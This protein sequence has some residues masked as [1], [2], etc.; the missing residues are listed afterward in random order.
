MNEQIV[1]NYLI[2]GRVGR[3]IVFQ[4][5]DTNLYAEAKEIIKS[6]PNDCVVSIV[7]FNADDEIYLTKFLNELEDRHKLLWHNYMFLQK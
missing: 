6:N 3:N 1:Q 2:G 5:S 7:D 4:N